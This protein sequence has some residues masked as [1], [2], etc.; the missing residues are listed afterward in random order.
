M[1]SSDFQNTRM[2]TFASWRVL[3]R[4]TLLT[5]VACG[6]FAL[7]PFVDNKPSQVFFCTASVVCK[8]DAGKV[9]GSAK[10]QHNK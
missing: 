10:A 8:S 6:K 4:K 7:C 1:Y 5:L 2:I 9:D 3:Y